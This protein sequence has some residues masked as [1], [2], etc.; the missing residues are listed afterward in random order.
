[1]PY[2]SILPFE[3][4]KSGEVTTPDSLGAEFFVFFCATG[5]CHVSRSAHEMV[6]KNKTKKLEKNYKSLSNRVLFFPFFSI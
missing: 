4:K 3:K 6:P 5:R 1:M 2:E